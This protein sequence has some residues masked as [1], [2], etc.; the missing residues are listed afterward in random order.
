MKA[1][2]HLDNGEE[3]EVDILDIFVDKDGAPKVLFLGP[4]DTIASAPTN[5]FTNFENDGHTQNWYRQ[6]T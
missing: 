1:V 4:D 3:E 6:H 2:F 5:R